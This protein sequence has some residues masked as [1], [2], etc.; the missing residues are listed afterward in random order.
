MAKTFADHLNF[1]DEQKQKLIIGCCLHD[2]GKILIPNEV[3]NKE[4][5]LT[6]K[7]WEVIKL[8]SIYGNKVV[9]GGRRHRRRDYQC[10][11]VSS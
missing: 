6:S 10:C 7:E 8:H 1:S 2:F 11:A 4:G 3:L 9:G 5:S